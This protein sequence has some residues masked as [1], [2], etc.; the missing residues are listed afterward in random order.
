MKERFPNL[1]LDI[2]PF[3]PLQ[4]QMEITPY[5][6]P[7]K[8]NEQMKNELRARLSPTICPAACTAARAPA[9][10]QASVGSEGRHR[11]RAWPA[12]DPPGHRPGR[13]GS[14]SE[15]SEEAASQRGLRGC[16]GCRGGGCRWRQE[17][18]KG[19]NSWRGE[20]WGSLQPHG[21]PGGV[22]GAPQAGATGA[23]GW[24]S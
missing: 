4:K 9:R 22:R 14:I 6:S 24:G 12:R 11:R 1:Q 20:G 15:G 5:L 16:A 7:P 3:S 17:G 18:K 8:A 21:S 2:L 19:K 10:H 23:W 13:A